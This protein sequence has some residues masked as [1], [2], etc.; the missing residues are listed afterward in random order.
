MVNQGLLEAVRPWPRVCLIARRSVAERTGGDGTQRLSRGTA[1]R[2]VAARHGVAGHAIRPDRI[3][4]DIKRVIAGLDPNA[5]RSELHEF[6]TEFRPHWSKSRRMAWVA[7][8]AAT[9]QPPPR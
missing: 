4:A 9:V 2:W 3:T 5:L 8:L 7:D 6:I 1:M